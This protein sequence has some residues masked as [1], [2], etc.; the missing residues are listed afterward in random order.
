[1]TCITIGRPQMRWRGLGREDRI[2]APSPAA[3]TIAETGMR[4]FYLLGR[5]RGEAGCHGSPV[6][7]RLQPERAGAITFPTMERRG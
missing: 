5:R 4:P 6:A 1:M 3:R 2:L 7:G